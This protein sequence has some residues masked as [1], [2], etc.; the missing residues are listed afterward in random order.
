MHPVVHDA[1]ML[2]GL[3]MAASGAYLVWGL[4]PALLIAGV[5]TMVVTVLEARS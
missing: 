1:S 3:A 5:C 2:A 4:G